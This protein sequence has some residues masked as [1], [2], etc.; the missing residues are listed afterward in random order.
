MTSNFRTV[1]LPT[2]ALVGLRRALRSQTEPGAVDMMLQIAGYE[3]GADMFATFVA[4]QSPKPDAVTQLSAPD[5][6]SQVSHF[7]SDTGWGAVS[8]EPLHP[9]IG[10]LHAADWAEARNEEAPSDEL[11]EPTDPTPSCTFS[12]GL[13]SR[14]FST[15]TSSDV[16]VIELACRAAGAEHCSFAFGSEAVIARLDERLRGGMALD[17]A[18]VGL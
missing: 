6:W 12:T 10:M 9:S 1:A 4:S 11:A 7:F 17:E 18:L 2:S 13:L 3:A 15:L 8:F 14:F 5:F 16:A